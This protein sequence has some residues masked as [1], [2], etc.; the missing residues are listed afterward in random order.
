[1]HNLDSDLL[2]TFLAIIDTGSMSAGAA[3]IGRSQSAVS[4]QVKRLEATLGKPVFT[5]HGR[6]VIPS[7]VGEKLEPVA[8]QT[9]SLLDA[10]LADIKSDELAGAIRLG[11]PDDHSKTVLAN[12]IAS[13]AEKHPLVEIN[14]R[15]A[16]GAEFAGAVADGHLD[17]ALYEV[18]TAEDHHQVL[19]E[20]KTFWVTSRLHSAHDL[21]PI[22]IALFDRDCWWRD[23]AL[24]TLRRS[25]LAY[26]VAYSSESVSGV[27]AAIRSGVA[28]GLLGQSSIDKD[29]RILT[30]PPGFAAMPVSKLVLDR[31]RDTSSAVVGAM[32]ET[33]VRAF[34]HHQDGRRRPADI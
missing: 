13:F 16:S 31:R 27:A 33:I 25:G 5:R 30:E 9:V 15:C 1:M 26:R 32:A 29:F 10:S 28:I 22:P 11:V 6:G 17:L 12:I 8:R 24:N 34:G 3:K 21:S 4:L 23:V 19:A 2:R 7:A 20:E 18:E 14:V